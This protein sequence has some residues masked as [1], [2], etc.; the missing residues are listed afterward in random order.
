MHDA[1]KRCKADVLK[2]RD[3]AQ[4]PRASHLFVSLSFPDFGFHV[5]FLNFHG[6]LRDYLHAL[7]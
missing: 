6:P 5:V 3:G 2:G 1:A 7:C 4:R